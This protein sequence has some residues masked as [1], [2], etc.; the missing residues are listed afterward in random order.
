MLVNFQMPRE[1]TVLF[2]ISTIGRYDK[3]ISALWI[4]PQNDFHSVF[5]ESFD[6]YIY[7]SGVVRILFFSLLY[8]YIRPIIDT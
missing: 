4:F 7:R 3:D 5:A 8:F 2:N 6:E 1:N